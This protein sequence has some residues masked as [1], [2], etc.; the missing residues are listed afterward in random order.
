V[1]EVA[2]PEV[3]VRHPQ[4]GLRVLIGSLKDDT[5][6][7]S[8]RKQASGGYGRTTAGATKMFLEADA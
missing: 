7:G 3:V 2:L 5:G 4:R 8:L 1:I 6:Y